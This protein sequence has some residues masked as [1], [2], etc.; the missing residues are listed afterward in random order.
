MTRRENLHGVVIGLGSIGNRHLKNLQQLDVGK[1]TVVRR[2]KTHNRHFEAPDGVSVSHDLTTT[3]AQQSDFAIV[4]NPTNLHVTTT[5]QCLEAS[6]HV[7]VEKPLSAVLDD[8]SRELQAFAD[9]CS[10]VTAMAYC[11]R[12][13][14][15]YR[16][17]REHV[18]ANTIGKVL[19]AKAW[20]EGYLPDWHPWEDY[21][22][23]YAARVDQ[24]GGVLRTLDHE[25]DFL[26]WVLGPAEYAQG[27]ATNT[28]SL[29]IGADDLA[30]YQLN[31]PGG[32]RS[33]VVTAFCRKPASR[34]FEFI[35]EAGTLSFQMEVGKLLHA[36]HDSPNECA[37]LADTTDYDINQMYVDLAD[38]FLNAICDKDHDRSTLATITDGLNC[39]TLFS[40]ID[41]T[42]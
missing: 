20:F 11:M 2:A 18:K 9:K 6:C 15:A 32:V 29:G 39:T 17:A 36:T 35:G 33:Q 31:H 23:S 25:L 37:V 28:G 40:Q 13:H 41:T 7:L 4:C 14:P 1:L 24:A 30:M 8:D 16:S 12:Y 22:T 19:Y 38:D 42:G 34:G 5:R 21:R 3:L 26:N 10:T 27:A